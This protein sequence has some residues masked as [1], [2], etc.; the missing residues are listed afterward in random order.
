MRDHST[1]TYGLV[2]SLTLGAILSCCSLY[3]DLDAQVVTE[4]RNFYTGVE[5]VTAGPDGNVWFTTDSG[6][7]RITADGI[8]AEVR[9]SPPAFTHG[10]TKG[11]DGN[12][13]FTV[14][15]ILYQGR[16]RIGR[17]S[18]LGG[19]SQFDVVTVKEQEL[20]GITAG[21][22]GNVWFTDLG[23]SKIG[24]ITPSGVITM[25]DVP[26]IMPREIVAGP[27]GN[28]WFTTQSD[29]IGRISPEGVVT[30][31]GIEAYASYITAGPDGN[32][33]F[34]DGSRIGR[35]TPAG[36]VTYFAS[37]IGTGQ[38]TVAIA[39]GSDG[40]LWFTEFP[41]PR[42]GRIT[43]SGVITEFA[44]GIHVDTQLFAITGGPDG[45]LWFKSGP[46]IS[47]ITTGVPV[48]TV[49]AVEFYNFALDHYFVT[50]VPA[51]IAKLDAGIEIGGWFRTGFTLNTFAE[52]QSGSS[53]VCRYYIPPG[54]GDSH[55]FGRGTVE[56]NA[57]GQKN[58][59]FVLEDPA[60]M[61]MFLPT[62]GVC[63]TN[64]TEVYR[65]FS[66]RADANHRYTIYKALRDQM[67]TKG[68]LAEG[69]G[70]DLVVMCAPP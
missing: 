55:F 3:G 9:L 4:F 58:P 36:V 59:S 14:P 16:G 20:W 35:I 70:P 62:S 42:I 40:N 56:C 23:G 17:M 30:K 1:T 7:A 52:S 11:P 64:T 41:A 57:T 29:V 44:D 18:P 45:A 27:D 60:F 22:D 49:R 15:G 53:P 61:Q 12:L 5:S 32:M 67:I 48:L 28:L 43:P 2:R 13:W 37:G 65:V 21:P 10:I 51:E 68:W 8:V 39:A 69:D 38:G 33:W 31:F 63:P 26:I 54:L 47:R 66:N 6:I 46:W 24:R 50:W 19:L 34:T 25:F